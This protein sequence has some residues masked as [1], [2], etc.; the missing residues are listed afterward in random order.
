MTTPKNDRLLKALRR[1]PVDRTP[2]WLMRQAG[3]YLPEYRKT[4]AEAG[5]FMSLCQNPA[6]ACEVTLQPLRRYALDAAILF[7]DILVIPDA[8]GQGLYFETGEGPRFRRKVSSAEDVDR[9]QRVDPTTDLAYALEAVQRIRHALDGEIP[10]I[11]FAG[12]PWTLATYMIEGG[13]SKQYTTSKAMLFDQPE[14]AH[15][16]LQRLSEAV[17]D[18]LAAQIA[19]GADVVQVFDSWGGVL[20]HDHYREF[21]LPYLQRIVERLKADPATRDT[22]VILF[23]KGANTQLE[24]LADTGCDGLS[25]DWTI[26]LSEARRRVGDRVTLQGNLDPAVLNASPDALQDAVDRVLADYGSGPGH[27]FNLGHGL[28]P[29]VPPEQVARLVE[30]VRAVSSSQEN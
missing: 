16:L 28:T 18:F 5:D 8:M 15:A 3:R 17:A 20:A 1:Q 19:A 23:S 21:N 10:L 6:L 11:G 30:R 24:A 22:P 2:V 12:S 9:L 13:S 7:C 27:I 4:R 29:G 25:L 26:S 14:T